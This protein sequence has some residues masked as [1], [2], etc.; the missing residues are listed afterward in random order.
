MNDANPLALVDELKRVLQRYITTTLP[1]NRRYPRLGMQFREL[2]AQ[3]TLVEGPYV[4]ALP[5]FEKGDALSV[6]LQKNGGFVH[7]AMGNLPTVDRKLHKHQ[8]RA[9]ELTAREG[10]SLLVATGTGSGKTECFLYPIAHALLSDPEPD[11]PGVRA[12]LIYPM[13]ALANDQLYYRIAPLLGK[14]LKKQGI[15]FGRYTGQVKANIKRDEEEARLFN[16]SK[17]MQALD[18][19]DE[20]PSNWMLTREEMLANPP[21]LLITNY[22]MLE[23]LLLLPRNERLFSANALRFIVLDEIHTYHGAQA[24]EVAF[25]LRKLKNRLQIERPLQVFGTSASLAEGEEANEK[26]KV[27][28]SGLFGETVHEVVRGKRIVHA[29]LQRPVPKEFSLSATEWIAIGAALEELATW[30]EDERSPEAW[31]HLLVDKGVIRTDLHS[32]GS[33]PLAGFLEEIFSSNKEIR[34]VSQLLDSAGIKSFTELAQLVFDSPIEM[35]PNHAKY[36]ALSAVIRLGMMARDDGNGF[37]LLPGRYHI[38]VNSIEGLAILPGSSDE[39][40]NKLKAARHY[41]DLDGQY[42]PLLT[43]RKCGQPFIEGFEE[44]GHL[45]NRRPGDRESRGER[46]VFWLGKPVGYVQDEDDETEYNDAAAYPKV[47]LNV[48]SGELAA[49]DGAVALY[50]IQT[51]KDESEKAWYVRKCPACGGR[52]SGADAEVVTRMHPGN[53]A[54]G[55]VVAQRVLESLPPGVIDNYTPRPALGRNLLTFSDNRQDAAF[56]APY[57]ERTAADLA[58][59]SAIRNILKE[60]TS[61]LT[62][63]QMA[64]QIYQYWQRDGQQ[65]VLLDGN[66][67]IVIDRQDAI[68]ILLG[69]LGAEFCTPGRRR[70]SVEALGVVQVSYDEQKL[71]FLTQKVKAFWPAA[72]PSDERNVHSLVHILLENIRRERAL[73]R[74]HQVPLRDAHIWG[75]Y[76]QHRTFDIEAGDGNVPYKWLPAQQQN[77]HNRRTW[78]LIEQLG[79]PRDQAFTFLRQFWEA[80]VKPPISL[81]ER[82]APGFG[83]NGDVI[84]FRN[85]D[86]LP[87]SVCKSC[88]LM[89]QHT[90]NSRCTAF[91]CRGEAEELRLEERNT[92]WANNHYLASYDEVNHTTVRAREHTA[93]L[94]T[95]LRE[96]IERDFAERKLNLLSCTTTMEMGVDLGDLEAVVNLN[97][98]PSIANYQQRTGRAGRRAQA[99]PFCVTIARNTNF[100]QAVVRAF[101]EY[102]VS[103]PTT[104]FI[105]LD[106]QEL[107]KRH[108]FSI[109][110]SHFL[111]WKITDREI[112]APSLR[113]L[114]GDTFTQDNLKN[115][116][117][118]LLQWFE[119]PSGTAAIDEAEKLVLRLPKPV[120]AIGATGIYLRHQFLAAIRE[121]AEEVRE[122]YGKYTERMDAAGATQDY[123]KAHYWQKMRAD[124]LGQFLVGQLSQRG[125]IPTYSFPVHSLNLDVLQESTHGYH[126]NSDV[127]LSRDASL[128]ISEYAPGAEVVANG[129]IWESAGLAHYPKA[130][131]P[132]RWY[133]ACAEC[134]HVD[135]G[136]VPDEIPP[137]CAN[138]GSAD[139]RRKRKFLEPH[140]FVTSYSQLRGRDPGSSRRKVKPADEARLIAA[141]RDELFEDTGLPFLL[142]AFLSAKIADENGVRGSLFIANRGAY[143]EGYHRCPKCNYSGPVKRAPVVALGKGSQPRSK[144][145][146]KWIHDDPQSG[147]R[148]PQDQMP[149][150]GLDFVHRFDTDVRL[151]RFVESM[152]SPMHV[153]MEPRRFHE[154]LAR[155]IA[156]AFRLAATTLLNLY[157]GEV[158]GIYRLYGAAGAKLEVVL[159]DAVPGGAGYTSRIGQPGFQFEQLVQIAMQ[160]LDCPLHCESG[161]RVCLCDY[162][163]QRYW[164]EFERKAAWAWLQS[165][166]ELSEHGQPSE[167]FVRWRSPSLAGLAERLSNY[168][169]ISLVARNLVDTV[170][171]S[172]DCLNQLI[173]WMQNGKTINLYLFS[174]LEDKPTAQVPLLIYRRLHPYVLE[175]RLKL[176]SIPQMLEIDLEGIPRIF[177]STELQSPI[178]HQH[179][180]TQAITQSLIAEPVDIGIVNE[181]IANTLTILLAKAEAYDMHVFQEGERMRMWELNKG[182]PREFSDI[183][184][185]ASGV[186]IKE[187]VIR[188]PYCAAPQHAKKLEAFL[189]LIHSYATYIDCVSVRCREVKDRDGYVEFYLDIERR[190]DDIIKAVGIEKWDVTAVPLKGGG[191][192][193]HDREIDI[194]TISQE[195]CKATHRYFLTGGIDYLMDPSAETRLFYIRIDK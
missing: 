124:F 75:D 49:K 15:T 189:K 92:L 13:N 58:L 157:P 163:N 43:C 151:F 110:L 185:V 137:A 188:D 164:D 127:A 186:H 176:F 141:P 29:R 168:Q 67:E 192:S 14:D 94:S 132:E 149:K 114:F 81:L 178:F 133:V 145:A 87:L 50:P 153:E 91:R 154:R 70:N 69:A 183:F 179:F 41:R 115:F 32:T 169:T 108:Q 61:L 66:G 166:L 22:A 80:L 7:D 60:R 105:H 83:L 16:N 128:G 21:K 72:L 71:R 73:C 165:L 6:L 129:R 62:A 77:W 10:K 191:K 18:H 86:I 1:I 27:F 180:A 17:L 35:D 158:R 97:V 107:F 182:K 101:R 126:G 55:S 79:V 28:A 90:V 31:N 161:C 130:F 46:R 45:H 135:I 122:R 95:D 195:G 53:E 84:R 143:G 48:K 193:F 44:G 156:E 88:G 8:Q 57:F 93:S 160:R 155:T 170:S 38:A 119:G 30:H 147:Q 106:N 167:N 138:C 150:I 89:Q 109:L 85:A 24:T 98:P 103:C 171:Y 172:E 63:P 184:A 23:H 118:Q 159:Y 142:S 3:Q 121:F 152:P 65:P 139:G 100:D 20:I 33:T 175:R 76:N 40:W 19:P 68:P 181:V 116:V 37:P 120:Q 82:Y 59:R 104:P 102:L 5:D 51:V 36:Q 64:E 174:K 125:L 117:E 162:S 140:G 136:D 39:G 187:L 54:L 134:F 99:A 194:V 42:Y 78:Y 47:W 131:M 2:L 148:C 123:K 25:L 111:R 146:Y 112:N 26:L 9:L 11:I 52:A 177:T 96:S 173:S 12:L 56:F 190:V 144:P 4:E 34:R 74:F 113:H